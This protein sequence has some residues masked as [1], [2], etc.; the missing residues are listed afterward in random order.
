MLCEHAIKRCQYLNILYCSWTFLYRSSVMISRELLY[1]PSTIHYT[2]YNSS[3]YSLGR[4]LWTLFV[5]VLAY[6]M[7]PSHIQSRIVHYKIMFNQLEIPLVVWL[8]Q[9]SNL[10]SSWLYP[11]LPRAYIIS[12]RCCLHFHLANTFHCQGDTVHSRWLLH[13]HGIKVC[14]KIR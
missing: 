6:I 7:K 4:L 12:H 9:S 13:C 3:T 8:L 11:V 10:R 14:Y 1:N 2:L 5:F